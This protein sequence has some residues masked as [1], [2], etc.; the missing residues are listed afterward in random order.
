M[1]GTG[2]SSSAG[3]RAWLARATGLIVAASVLLSIGAS[4]GHTTPS[5]PYYGPAVLATHNLVGY[6]PLDETSGTT[7]SD[8]TSSPA[9][10][11]YAGGFTLG[12]VGG[13]TTSTDNAVAFNGS[14]G[15]MTVPSTSKLQ[16]TASLTVEGWFKTSATGSQPIFQSGLSSGVYLS[17]L[18]GGVVQFMINGTAITSSSAYDDGAWHYV[19]GTWDGSYLSLYVDGART[20]PQ[21]TSSNPQASA[22]APSYS[23]AGIYLAVNNTGTTHFS[24]SLDEFAVYGSNSTTSGALS[25]GEVANHYAAATSGPVETPVDVVAPTV[26]GRPLVGSSF[27]VSDHGSWNSSTEIYGSLSYSYQWLRCGFDGTACISISGATG[28]SYT[29]SSVDTTHALAVRVKASNASASASV[30]VALPSVGGY[31]TD[32][33]TDGGTNLRAYWPLDDR[34]AYVVGQPAADIADSPAPGKYSSGVTVGQAGPIDDGNDQAATFDG[35]TGKV[36]VPATSKL[37]PSASW[38]LEAWVK[39]T[40]TTLTHPILQSGN[41]GISLALF[42]GAPQVFGDG[43]TIQ[44][45]S[46]AN[47]CADGKWHYVV[48]T[49][50]GSNLRLYVD[51]VLATPA[52]GSSNPKATTSAPSYGSAGVFIGT[53]NTGTTW[54]PG[55]ID[56]P[57]IYGSNTDSSGALSA[58]EIA[59]HYQQASF[60][61]AP[62]GWRR[63]AGNNAVPG[64]ISAATGDY[65]HTET[66]ASVATFGPSLQFVRTYDSSLAQAQATAGTPGPLGYGWTDN[67]NASLSVSSGVVT[68]TQAN[69]AQVTFYPPVSGACQAPYVGPGSAGT[70]CALPEVTASLTYSSGTYTFTTHPYMSYTFNSS[71][72][73]TSESGPGGATVTLAYSTPA[74]GSGRCPSGAHVCMT[75]TSA[76]GRSLVIAENSSNE[77]TSVIDPLSRSWSYGYCSPPSSTCSAN[78]LVSVTDPLTHVTSYTYDEPNSTAGLKHDL[79][80]VMEPNGQSGGPDAGAKETVAYNSLGQETSDTDQGGYATSFDYTHLDSSSVTSE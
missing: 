56:E 21:S 1:L 45:T 70:Y 62:A 58:A 16:P 67:W 26:G 51:G 80:T 38:T 19:V 49:W 9:N 42:Y 73:L 43:F 14:T 11:T 79:L 40:T 24:G 71:G 29:V 77:I 57:A 31:R 53:N 15:K 75:V 12:Q 27:S 32:V 74:P 66:D 34:P 10:G 30:T 5:P 25:A 54:F 47:N 46:S 6:W 59:N 41:P 17:L 33:F 72:Q 22:T 28:S 69:G 44:S 35:S 8:Q 13:V 61:V 50:D 60:R 48:G 23:S 37:Q 4:N 68:V 7:A 20:A 78:D 18:S 65:T 64:L 52:S 36:T 55:S 3:S 2:A 76:S 63:G 39:T